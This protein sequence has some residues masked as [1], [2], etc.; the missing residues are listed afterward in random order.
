MHRD[1]VDIAHPV[2]RSWMARG[3]PTA[4]ESPRGYPEKDVFVGPDGMA[5]LAGCSAEDVYAA[6]HD[7]LG[8]AL[9]VERRRFNV[10]HPAALAFF[11]SHPL[12]DEDV[13]HFPLAAAAVGED[14]DVDHPHAVVFRTRCG[15]GA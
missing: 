12:A 14:I 13:E 10:T 9:D 5:E 7:G 2:T 8:E 1:R 6:L 4:P 3:R 11:A 15:A